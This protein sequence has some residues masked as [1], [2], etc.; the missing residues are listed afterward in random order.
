MKKDSH[1]INIILES[2]ANGD[3][4]VRACGQANIHY[5]TFL[6]WYE[7]DTE[8]SESVKKAE[9][10]GNDRIKDLAKRGIIEKFNNNWQSAAW[11]LERNYPDE[12]RQRQDVHQ[13]FEQRPVIQIVDL[14]EKENN[15]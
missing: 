5:S 3:G 15:G 1:H 4:R 13:S 9:D 14:H 10:T 11:W 8:F 12:F 2:L 6:D 7:H